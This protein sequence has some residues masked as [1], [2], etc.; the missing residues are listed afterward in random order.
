MQVDG[1]VQDAIKKGAKLHVGGKPAKNIGERFY[2]PT[3]LTD[4]TDSMLCYREEIFGPVVVC[5]K[6]V[7]RVL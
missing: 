3:L 7:L 2:E 6:W 5:L 4:I 1:I